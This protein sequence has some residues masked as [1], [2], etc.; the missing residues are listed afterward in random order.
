MSEVN[1]DEVA[2]S[3]DEGLAADLGV[4]RRRF[5][6]GRIRSYLIAY[7]WQDDDGTTIPSTTVNHDVHH[8]ITSLGLA[9][10]A[11]QCIHNSWERVEPRE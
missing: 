10:H 3:A 2:S 6:A 11:Q 1:W 4:F 9:V 7:E 5:E 8:P